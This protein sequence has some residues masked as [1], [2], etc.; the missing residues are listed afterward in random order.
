[1]FSTSEHLYDNSINR[2]ILSVSSTGGRPLVELTGSRYF[3]KVREV[4][5][6]PFIQKTCRPRENTGVQHHGIIL[7]ANILYEFY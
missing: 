1:M 6:D 4:H 3:V 7:T 2:T 5:T